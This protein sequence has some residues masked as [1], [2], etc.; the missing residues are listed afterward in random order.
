MASSSADLAAG[1]LESCGSEYLATDDSFLLALSIDIAAPAALCTESS[2]TAL[3]N[4][5]E[6]CMFKRMQ[7]VSQGWE[8][9]K[10]KVSTAESFLG[11]KAL[12]RM[13]TLCVS[14]CVPSN[15]RAY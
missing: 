10:E 11:T 9:V 7:P 8:R 14:M 6:K 1:S 15:G 5:C 13:A 2:A 12:R 3:A 4:G